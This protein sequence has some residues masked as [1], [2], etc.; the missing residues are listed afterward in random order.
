MKEKA[1]EEGFEFLAISLY[2][3][4]LLG[5]LVNDRRIAMGEV[6]VPYAHYGYA[7]V[8]ALVLGKLVLIGDAL[9]LGRGNERR[10]LVVSALYKSLWFGAFVLTFLVIEHAI[11]A[12]VEGQPLGPKLGALFA[13]PATVISLV[14]LV[15]MAFIPFFM[16]REAG[17]Q[18]GEERLWSLM[19]RRPDT[20]KPVAAGGGQRRT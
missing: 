12:L 8:E 13:R 1:K 16:L 10:P 3:A 14:L 11:H 15:I 6:G 20:A 9:H 18:L 19:F 4:I 17:R 5:A 7:V 2:F